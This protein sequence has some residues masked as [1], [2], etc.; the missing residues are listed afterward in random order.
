VLGNRFRDRPS[1]HGIRFATCSSGERRLVAWALELACG[2]RGK[3]RGREPWAV[4]ASCVVGTACSGHGLSSRWESR[5]IQVYFILQI[6][7]A[8]PLPDCGSQGQKQDVASWRA[9]ERGRRRARLL[10][11]L[12]VR[13]QRMRR[14]ICILAIAAIGYPGFLEGA[15]RNALMGCL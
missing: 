8:V 10:S 3:L 4:T 9:D 11:N 2:H 13:K 1:T 14:C 12:C 6:A 15:L 5:Q 7:Y